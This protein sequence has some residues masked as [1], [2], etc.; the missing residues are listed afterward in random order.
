M[1]SRENVMREALSALEAQRAQ[2]LTEEKRRRAEAAEKSPE[3]A[4]LMAERQ[5]VFFGGMRGAF[6]SP[7]S[8]AEISAKMQS[9][10]ERINAGMRRALVRA[11][12]PEDYLQPV[13]RC[14]L[15]RDTGY[16]GEPV[17]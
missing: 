14:R 5:Q 4:K 8:A 9:D 7:A 3:I 16:V 10:M 2:N 12:F 11:G 17:H 1:L 13:Y 15:C 6:S